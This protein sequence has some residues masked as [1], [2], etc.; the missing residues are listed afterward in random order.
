MHLAEYLFRRLYELKIRAIF[1]VPGDFNLVALDLVEKC[2]LKWVGNANELNAGYAADG[3]AR[4]K[5]ISAIVTTFGVGELSALNALAGASA[6]LV[7]VI[8]IVGFP[9]TAVKDKRLP[10]HHT[11]GDG[12]FELFMKMSARLS[13]AVAML[14]SAKDAPKMI[15]DTIIACVRSSKPVYIGLPMDFVM[16]DVD[17]SSLATPL[18]LDDPMSNPIAEEDD[19]VSA[20]MER[21]AMA[22]NPAILVD[23]LAGRWHGLQP[24]R[25]FVEKSKIPCYSFPMAKG[26]IDESLPNFHGI[27]SGEV[28]EDGVQEQVQLSDLIIHIG[29]RPTDLNTAGF[30][31]DLPHI[32]TISF[33]RDSIHLRKAD[34]SS[35]HMNGVLRKLSESFCPTRSNSMSSTSGFSSRK[36]EES[37]GTDP[38]IDIGDSMDAI[39]GRKVK[40]SPVVTQ[41]RMWKRVSSWLEEDDIISLD[42]GTSAFGSLWTRHPRGTESLFQL[43]WSSIGFALGA[44]VGAAF[45]AREQEAEST[46]PRK[47]R[48][49]LFTGDGS[50]QM[51]A[52]EVSTMV[53]HKLG[54]I[55]FV[56]CNDGYT[57]ER[58]VHGW[59]N[60][61]NDIQPWDFKLLPSVFK[62]DPNTV[63]TYSVHTEAE[64][65]DVLTDAQFG[66]AK[67]FEGQEYTPLRLVEIHMAKEDAPRP[68]H[69]IIDAICRQKK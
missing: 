14:D 55:I 34:F 60:S 52:Q 48:T 22:R 17:A 46:P 35:L 11:L 24:T 18:P 67:N 30:K 31:S 13:G 27:Y 15:D 54:V 64:L 65:E 21:I 68:M 49:I 7:P 19:A 3:Y 2:G 58:M 38:G 61:Y 10:M 43:L 44:A 33:H 29:P 57:I 4:V 53:R 36:S 37:A 63:R 51:T 69:N 50:F 28:S 12:D 25:A 16:V 5:G 66:P 40:S 47:R 8:H 39:L 9:S 56:I 59:D 62:P 6:E 1:G 20:V 23:S 42:I 26:I 41:D 45:A 32:E